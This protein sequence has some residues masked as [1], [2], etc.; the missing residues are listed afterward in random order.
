MRTG[1]TGYW[2]AGC[3]AA[4]VHAYAHASANIAPVLRALQRDDCMM[5]LD[6]FFVMPLQAAAAARSGNVA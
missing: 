3:A 1:L 4:A 6:G 2:G 5:L